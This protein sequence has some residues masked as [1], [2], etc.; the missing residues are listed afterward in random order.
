MPAA[1]ALAHGKACSKQKR[2][3][4]H[5]YEAD[6]TTPASR[7][8]LH[9]SQSAA[10]ATVERPSLFGQRFSPSVLALPETR[11]QLSFVGQR[12]VNGNVWP[13]KDPTEP[14]AP[15]GFTGSDCTFVSI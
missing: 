11:G 1:R 8:P 6:A 4:D 12:G 15:I 9:G 3:C 14:K 7:D 10:F 13:T 5:G 2:T